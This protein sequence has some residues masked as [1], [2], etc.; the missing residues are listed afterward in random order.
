MLRAC[1]CERVLHHDEA[2]LC[3]MIRGVSHNWT[4]WF[5]PFFPSLLHFLFY[6]FCIFF[7]Y[8]FF[9]LTCKYWFCKYWYFYTVVGKNCCVSTGFHL[10]VW[11]CDEVLA[12]W[13]HDGQR[14]S[15]TSSQDASCYCVLLSL[16]SSTV[17]G[18]Q[19]GPVRD[20]KPK[21]DDPETLQAKITGLE[22][23]NN[24]RFVVWARTSSGR[25]KMAYVDVQTKRGT[26]KSFISSIFF[27]PASLSSVTHQWMMICPFFRLM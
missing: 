16:L 8:S 22:P 3:I 5:L 25:G 1:V 14:C 23:A 7:L 19:L 13:R 4:F 6:F 15:Q 26:S 18:T 10:N 24:Y 20:L 21:I 9:Y 2:C 27:R 11:S 17:E 12:N